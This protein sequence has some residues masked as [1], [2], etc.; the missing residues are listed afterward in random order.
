VKPDVPVALGK[1]AGSLLVEVVPAVGADYLQRN[2]GVTAILLQ[3]ATEEWDRAAAR[4]VEENRALRALLR[5][6]AAVAAD[7]S[8][9]GRLAEA[10]TASDDD[11]RISA[12]DAA[13]ARLRALL[14]EL[15]AHVESLDAPAARRLEDA[16]WDELRRS[17][18]RR[19]L[20]LAPF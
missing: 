6:G 20:S 3:L 7:A 8:L 19:T 12:L 10:A 13:N 17:T 1:L 5:E 18:E 15:H 2:T 14:I 9:R 11:L 16:I 4:R